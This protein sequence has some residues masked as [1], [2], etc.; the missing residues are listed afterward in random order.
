MIQPH[1]A[2][3][4]ELAMIADKIHAREFADTVVELYR[5]DTEIGPITYAEF[6]VLVGDDQRAD[7]RLNRMMVREEAEAYVAYLHTVRRNRQ[8]S[9]RLIA[10]LRAE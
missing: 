3:L 8:L 4:L 10:Q 7:D 1:A 5:Y 2:D 6:Q 9:A